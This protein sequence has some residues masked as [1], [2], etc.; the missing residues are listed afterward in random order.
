[1][2]YSVKEV[3]FSQ[4]D[5]REVLGHHLLREGFAQFCPYSNNMVDALPVP[6]GS[7]CAMF[8]LNKRRAIV[9]L[10]CCGRELTVQYETK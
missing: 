2:K 7:W 8:E 9:H 3:K 6:C 4:E 1:M 10:H 5:E